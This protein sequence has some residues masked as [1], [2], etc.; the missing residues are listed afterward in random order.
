MRLLRIGVKGNDVLLLQRLLANLGY[1]MGVQDAHFGPV[2]R[3]AVVSFQLAQGLKG[4]GIVGP[5]TMAA[6]G[7][8][9]DVPEPGTHNP[10]PRFETLAEIDAHLEKGTVA[11][12]EAAFKIIQYDRGYAGSVEAAANR[13]LKMRPSY[14]ELERLRGIPWYMTG[15]IHSLECSNNPKGVLH[16]G[17]PIVGTTR[18]TTIVPKGRGPFATWIEAALDAVDTEHLWRVPAWT[19]GWVLK[20]CEVF[21]GVGYLKYH[22]R[23][24]SPYLW[25]Q[26][27]IND[28]SGKYISDGQWSESANA[29][30]QTGC[31][32]ILHELNL[33]GEVILKYS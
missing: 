3:A 33:R 25:A 13:V 20:Q 15:L 4:D 8:V 23:E 30:T 11:W 14:D 32:A 29:N 17:Q 24:N 27:N 22:S 9:P 12:Y 21:N 16:N 28:G 31:A 6:F 5:M 2:T 1:Y 26:T 7:A 18:K 10:L 19:V